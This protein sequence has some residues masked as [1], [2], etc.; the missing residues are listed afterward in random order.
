MWIVWALGVGGGGGA[1]TG[2]WTKRASLAPVVKKPLSTQNKAHETSLGHEPPP[3]TTESVIS[4]H[5]GQ[6]GGDGGG[7]GGDGGAGGAMASGFVQSGGGG[8]P[9][10]V[11]PLVSM[12]SIAV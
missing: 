10:Q 3:Q 5:V 4:P 9:V 8:G 7:C 6:I 12:G 2:G 1:W 11:A